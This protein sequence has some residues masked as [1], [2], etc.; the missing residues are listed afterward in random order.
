MSLYGDAVAAIK[1][2]ILIDERVQ[3]QSRKVEKLA[4]EVLALRERVVRLE[5]VI[6]VLLQGRGPAARMSSRSRPSITD[7]NG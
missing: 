6:E 2:I 4:D 5:A 7:D 3:S 1:S